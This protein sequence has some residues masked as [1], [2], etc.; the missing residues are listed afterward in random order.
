[1]SP[2]SGPC[3]GCLCD[4]VLATMLPRHWHA[5]CVTT[6]VQEGKSCT[7]DS[8]NSHRMLTADIAWSSRRCHMMPPESAELCKG[9]VSQYPTLFIATA[10]RFKLKRFKHVLSTMI[11]VKHRYVWSSLERWR[12]CVQAESEKQKQQVWQVWQ[13][14]CCFY[15]H[16]PEIPEQTLQFKHCPVQSAISATTL[17]PMLQKNNEM[18]LSRQVY[19][20]TQQ[21]LAVRS[22]W[23][24]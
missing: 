19:F 21:R 9:R 5:L 12:T 10:Y 18:R 16:P 17:L 7:W 24:L 14:P 8:R 11:H 2:A 22:D 20:R 13:G 6:Q 4:A 23:F 3:L 1:M 15:S